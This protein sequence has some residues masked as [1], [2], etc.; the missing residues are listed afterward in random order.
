MFIDAAL[1]RRIKILCRQRTT[2][3]CCN[4]SVVT[5]SANKKCA[6]FVEK[7]KLTSLDFLHSIINVTF[8]NYFKKN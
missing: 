1:K 2:I 7:I 6:L 3:E 5:N 8:I 4:M